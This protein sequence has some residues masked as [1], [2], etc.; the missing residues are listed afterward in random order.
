MY[1]DAFNIHPVYIQSAYS[2]VQSHLSLAILHVFF[3]DGQLNSTCLCAIVWAGWRQADPG[4][5]I[6]DGGHGAVYGWSAGG[7]EKAVDG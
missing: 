6:K 2:I 4:R 3:I 5:H 1:L 7:H